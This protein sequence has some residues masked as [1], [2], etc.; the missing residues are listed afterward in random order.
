MRIRVGG[1]GRGK[2]PLSLSYYSFNWID[3]PLLPLSRVLA[4]GFR[5]VIFSMLIKTTLSLSHFPFSVKC[6]RDV[7][8]FPS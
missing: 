6:V 7:Y 5:L 3:C 1:A 4:L 2:T 8:Y